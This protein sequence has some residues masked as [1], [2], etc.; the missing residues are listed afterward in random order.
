MTEAMWMHPTN[1]TDKF[2]FNKKIFVTE[3]RSGVINI[4]LSGDMILYVWWTISTFK[5]LGLRAII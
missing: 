4:R 1:S 5:T 2:W 3:D